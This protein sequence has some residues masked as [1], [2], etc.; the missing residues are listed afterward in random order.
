MNYIFV[1]RCQSKLSHKI[2]NIYNTTY[3]RRTTPG[4]FFYFGPKYLKPYFFFQ[5]FTPFKKKLTNLRCGWRTYRNK[6][7]RCPTLW[8]YINAQINGN[9]SKWNKNQCFTR[10]N[11]N[12]YFTVTS[13]SQ[14]FH[15][16]KYQWAFSSEK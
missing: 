2:V 9:I 10:R 15:I 7:Q 16:Q 8:C 5:H 6:K 14:H 1:L 12:I 13:Q 4:I 3:S 11:K